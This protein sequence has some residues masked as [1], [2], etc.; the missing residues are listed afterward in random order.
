MKT[1]L[2]KLLTPHALRFDELYT[3]LTEAEA[4]LNSRPL[5]PLHS[6]EMTNGNYL[7]AEHFLIGRP[8]KAAP[9][10]DP[11]TTHSLRKYRVSND[12]TWSHVRQWT[13]GR[14]G[15]PPT[16]S[17]S[18]TGPNGIV[19]ADNSAS[20]ILSYR[21]WPIAKVTSLHP[22]GD[23]QTCAVSLLCGDKTLIRPVVR[24]SLC[25]TILKNPHLL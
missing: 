24:L 22:G 18:T 14:N 1:Q 7:T 23:A 5:T 21:R 6:D 10:H 2:R 4:I 20:V 12:G 8:I 19:L 17:H 15:S 11:P 16:F 25:H 13:F 3:V 9:T